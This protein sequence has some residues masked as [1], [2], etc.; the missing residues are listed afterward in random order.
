MPAPDAAPLP[1]LAL[2][3]RLAAVLRDCALAR[4][5]PPAITTETDLADDLLLDSLDRVELAMT[6]EER[7]GVTIGDD[8]MEDCATVADLLALLERLGVA[9]ATHAEV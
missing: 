5:P 3:P 6:L 9:P 7:F 4:C 8:E 2:L 1:G